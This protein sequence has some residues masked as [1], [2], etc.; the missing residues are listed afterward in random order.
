MTVEIHREKQH[1]NLAFVYYRG[2]YSVLYEMTYE[3]DLASFFKSAKMGIKNK[4]LLCM[5]AKEFAKRYVLE[6]SITVNEI[7]K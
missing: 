2:D 5:E 6:H 7:K 3:D 1:G 4:G